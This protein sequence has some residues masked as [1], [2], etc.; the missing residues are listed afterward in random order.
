MRAKS[1]D[2]SV[3]MSTLPRTRHHSTFPRLLS[4]AL[5]QLLAFCGS[6]DQN[7]RLAAGDTLNKIIK[8]G[9]ALCTL[10]W[11]L[12]TLQALQQDHVSRLLSDLFQEIKKVSWL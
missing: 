3:C 11:L 2:A 4:N 12:A 5:G 8:V 9:V 7:V 1:R 10:P 6:H